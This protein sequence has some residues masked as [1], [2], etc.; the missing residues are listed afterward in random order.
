QDF[1]FVRRLLA[2]N[3]VPMP[4]DFDASGFFAEHHTPLPP[5]DCGERV[6]LQAMLGVMGNLANGGNCTLL[7]VGLNSPI[8]ASPD[9][10]P[11]LNLVV[12]VDVSGSM[13]ADGKLDFVRDGLSQ[14]VA[15]LF[16]DDQLAIVKYSD[17]AEVVFELAPMRGHRND[18]LRAV[19]SLVPEGST[20]LHDG[21]RMG[22][23]QALAAYDS[24]RQNRVILL[25]DGLPTA[26]I[27]DTDAILSMS[28]RFN[29][30]GVGLT[31]VGLG[32]DFNRALMSGLAQQGD[33]NFYFLE[34]AAAVEEVFTEE[35]SYFTVP[36]AF[37]VHLR[38][39]EGSDFRLRRAFGSPLFAETEDG[40]RLD[41][42]SVFLAHRVAHDDVGPG[43]GRRGG[44]S[45]LLIELEPVD[46]PTGEAG[47]ATVGV[48]EI[49]FREPG[50]DAIIRQQVEVRSPD[51]PGTLRPEGFFENRIVEKSFVMLNIYVGMVMASEA[52]HV[53]RAPEAAIG[54][55]QRV[56]AAAV[57]Y[58]DSANDGAGDVDIDLDI[59]LMLDFI[60]VIEANGGRPPVESDI[61]EDPWPAD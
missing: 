25:S 23:E 59:E 46:E 57:D 13:E 14:T 28:R 54:I 22:Y 40:G 36:V 37:D 26:G 15:E 12:V 49:E 61:P 39:R 18:M 32:L 30:D 34:N 10:R 2:A 31:T 41:V 5:P 50:S 27:T 53:E 16:D 52:F 1:G 4:D 20:N 29:S 7:Q 47:E 35:L 17:R 43:N 38:V 58:E 24:G 8:A 21:L 56:V 44:G 33:G 55:L 60:R 19:E 42:P 51:A 3:R 45:A 11:P 9:N 48:V 6:C